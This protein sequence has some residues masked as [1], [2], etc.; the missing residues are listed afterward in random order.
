MRA[1]VILEKKND[2]D[3]APSVDKIGDKKLINH[4]DLWHV[5]YA[6]AVKCHFCIPASFMLNISVNVCDHVIRPHLI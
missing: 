3:K 1:F 6:E 2:K 4:V 5:Q